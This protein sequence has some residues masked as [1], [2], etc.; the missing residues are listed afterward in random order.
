MIQLNRV[1][2]R[3]AKVCTKF[4]ENVELVDWMK[5]VDLMKIQKAIAA[6]F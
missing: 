5:M 3:I 6:S 4:A 2:T 1:R